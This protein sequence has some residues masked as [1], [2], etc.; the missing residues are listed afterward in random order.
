MLTL[1][2]WSLGIGFSV[3]AFGA[4]SALQ[5]PKAKVEFNRDVRPILDKCLSCHGHDPKAIQAGLRLDSREGAT[6]RLADGVRAIVPGHPELSELIARINDKTPAMRMP[7]PSSNRILSAEDKATL[8]EWIAQGA[9]YKRHWAFVKPVRFSPPRVLL[10]TWPRN[11]IDTFVLAKLE[12]NGLK[13]SIEADRSTILRRVSLDLTGLPPSVA[14]QQAFLGDKSPG[15]YEKV[16]D[17]LLASP[18]YGERMAMDWVD[19]ARYADSNGYQN[20]YERYQY[21]WRD[22][23]IDAFNKNMPYDEFTVEQL[24]GDLLPHPTTDQIVATGFCR[25]NRMN[26][27]GGAI[28]E[29]YHTEYVIDRVQTMSAVWLGLTTGCARCHDHKYDPI[30]QKEFYSLCSYF[31]NVPETDIGEERPMN[32]PPV[33]QAPYPDQANQ[34]AMLTRSIQELQTKVNA[35]IRAGQNEAQIAP[36]STDQGDLPAGRIARYRFG[37]TPAATGNG[38]ATPIVVG[39]SV[40]GV[41]RS[42]GSIKTDARSYVNLGSTGDFE[43]NR[44]FS[45]GAWL[46]CDSNNGSPIAKMD[47]GAD[48]RGW[49]L[50]IDEGRPT[51]H[52]IHHWPDD[53][54][55]VISKRQ[56]PRGAWAHVFATYDGTAKAKGLH[57]YIDGEEVPF[58]VEVDHLTGTIRTAVDAHV[59]RRSSGTVYTGEVDDL[60]LYDR[61][62]APGEVKQLAG[63]LASKVLLS[64]PVDRRTEAQKREI[65]RD[66]LIATDA[67]FKN[68]ASEQDTD[69]KRKAKLDA[70]IPTVMVMKEMPKPRD[71]FVLIRGV[72]DHHGDKVAAATPAFM[73]SI[74]KGLTNNRL[75]LARWIVSPENPLTARVTVN[76]MWERLFGTGIVETSEDF[77]TRSSFPSHPELLDWLA[78]ELIA[79]KWDM[80]ALWK[81]M[82]M[83]ATYRQSSN[84]TPK[85]LALDPAN[86]LLARGPRFRLSA[87]VIRDQAMFAGGFMTERIG[88][89]SVR[90]YQPKGVWD[91]T[92]G[93][94]GN[95]RDYK[96]DTGP[97]LHRRSLYTIWKRTAAPPDMVL[98]DAPSREI[99]S[100]RRPRTDTPLQALTL[101]NDETF[102]EAARG[103]AQRV[104]CEAAS[105]G[106]RLERA[107]RLVLGRAPTA[108]ETAIL[109]KAVNREAKRYAANPKAADDLVQVGDL[110]LDRKH[111]RAEIAAY[112]L[113]ASTILNMDEAV[114]KR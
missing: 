14:E 33:V 24:A 43:W 45:Y 34:M 71:M 41:G 56:I 93:L 52:I 4:C 97:N 21:R 32:Y 69:E 81:E 28:P 74:P 19:C 40:A 72:Y 17:R 114:T 82:V 105:P 26:T 1:R 109:T 53:A 39:P 38:L 89:P 112:T 25:N 60:A 91:E 3:L 36:P 94:N 100:V 65:T 31:N 12:S 108:S 10:K 27:E 5:A 113:V 110:P 57:L 68:L 7:P 18:R 2:N 70:E 75:A 35:K 66:W 46:K 103:L 44:P 51:I 42:T 50:N 67:A 111:S 92:A 55:K 106:S 90:P 102:V 16:V 64:I 30:S 61:A 20:D 79:K 49:D 73:P 13:P 83:S 59:G 85:L 37:G 101:L 77:G 96:N 29:E 47:E 58:N 107:F 98:F 104:L 54:I 80:K 9:E 78:T 48:Y 63:V 23:V 76:R 99:C 11:P 87:E 62:L 88:G 95:L 86:R 22:W 6:K 84:V 15:A 8:K